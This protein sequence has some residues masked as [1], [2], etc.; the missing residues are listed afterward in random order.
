MNWPEKQNPSRRT[1]CS[2]GLTVTEV[3]T[4]DVAPLDAL[5]DGEVEVETELLP[6]SRAGAPAT[7]RVVVPVIVPA[8]AE[9]VVCPMLTPVE[10]PAEGPSATIVATPGADDCHVAC[11]VT[12]HVVPSAKVPVP[13]SC[14]VE[15]DATTGAG[16]ATVTETRLLSFTTAVA[17][18]VSWSNTAVMDAAPGPPAVTYPVLTPMVATAGFDDDQVASVVTS[19]MDPFAYVAVAVNASSSGGQKPSSG[20]SSRTDGATVTDVTGFAL[21]EERLA[22]LDIVVLPTDVATVVDVRVGVDA[23]VDVPASVDAFVEVP[24]GVDAVVD[25]PAGV[26]AFVDVP[27]S[28]DAFVPVCVDAVVD[29]ADVPTPRSSPASVGPVDALDLNPS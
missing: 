21:L 1:N 15:P 4:R 26:D 11:A 8:V 9:I 10:S 29:D 2:L 12:S 14:S 13:V 22:V 24:V 17:E 18:P 20:L 19:A 27:A 25:V 3:R 16:G 6:P 7:V 23:V 5:P 28:V